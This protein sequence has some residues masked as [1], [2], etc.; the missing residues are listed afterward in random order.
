MGRRGPSFQK[1]LV[2]LFEFQELEE[3]PDL[4]TGLSRMSHRVLVVDYVLVTTPDASSFEVSSVDEVGDDPLG[5][6]L[7]DSDVF[8]DV[9]ESN[10]RL[11]RDP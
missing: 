10:V 8:S 6:T 4:V 5:G 3:S 7:C 2:R 9:A 11:L 1:P